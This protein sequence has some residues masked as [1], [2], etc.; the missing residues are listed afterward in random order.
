MKHRSIFGDNFWGAGSVFVVM[1]LVLTFVDDDVLHN[2]Q[3]KLGG[4]T[5]QRGF[6]ARLPCCLGPRLMFEGHA[7][8][9]MCKVLFGLLPI[10]MFEVLRSAWLTSFALSIHDMLVSTGHLRTVPFLRDP[11][12]AFGIL[13]YQR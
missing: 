8:M 7:G 3:A 5:H 10:R 9:S 2:M 12:L 11:D 6:R 4:E 1:D 13:D